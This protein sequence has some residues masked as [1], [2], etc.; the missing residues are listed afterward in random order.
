MIV[1]PRPERDAERVAALHGYALLDTPGEPDFDDLAG[2]AA[3][4][5]GVPIAAV[6]LV[7]AE[8]QWFKANIGLEAAETPR[9]VAFCAHAIAGTGV[10][11]VPDAAADDRFAGNPLV[12][13]GPM[14][15]FYAGA[16]LVNRDGH[17]LGT[18]CVIDREPR[19][20][21]EERIAALAA[22]ARQA[23]S[24]ME[25]RRQAQA[26]RT[27]VAEREATQRARDEL[28]GQLRHAQR[29]QSVGTLAVGLANEVEAPMQ[30]VAENL[31]FVERAALS[32][33]GLLGGTL[34]PTRS[35]QELIGRLTAADLPFIESQLPRSLARC[36]DGIA[37]VIR[38]IEAMQRFSGSPGDM[39]VTD[40]N[41]CL[42]DTLRVCEHDYRYVADVVT[43]LDEL[44]PVL[45]N[46]GDMNQVFRNLIVNAA[47][48][49][50]HTGRRGRI[51]VRTKCVDGRAVIRIEDNGCGIEDAIRERIFDPFFTTRADLDAAG[52]GLSIAHSIV[53]R[54]H[55]GSMNFESIAGLG[56]RFI[57]SLPLNG[58][59]ELAGP[60]EPA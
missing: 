13:G 31:R 58:P 5:C 51:A 22:I 33:L 52:Q 1:P 2:L 11:V 47:Q 3:L 17:A 30:V 19:E 35:V 59:A 48:A 28:E 46:S 41:Q 50:E 38:L 25:L 26:L 36:H 45:A 29:L 40:L 53:V 18:L 49:I 9:D 56:T 6:S 15:R 23:V 21:G 60:G 10:F 39:A 57:V 54:R 24:L 32:L 42:R 14:I 43:E 37:R 55:G 8:R 12:T 34:N 7:D 16:P 44:P 27:L 20:L 4:I